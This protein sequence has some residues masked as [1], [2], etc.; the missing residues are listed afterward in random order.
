MNEPEAREYSESLG[1]IF[2]GGYR[3]AAWADKH[4]IPQALGL[5]LREWVQTYLGG[6]VRMSLEQ[7]REAVKELAAG[8]AN[9]T[10]I[11]RSLGLS[12]HTVKAD[13]QDIPPQEYRERNRPADEIDTPADRPAD[14]IAEGGTPPPEPS[15]AQV[16]APDLRKEFE[17]HL[18]TVGVVVLTGF[19][20]NQATLDLLNVDVEELAKVPADQKEAVLRDIDSVIGKLD[21][22]RGQLS[23]TKLEAV[24]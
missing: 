15:E 9:P 13:L 16:P 24:K 10:A 5:S 11:A 21:A 8:G 18:R 14:E 12:P 1:Q 2:D 23:V 6:Y 4:R 22:V 19:L 20:G 17:E 3:Q 7:R